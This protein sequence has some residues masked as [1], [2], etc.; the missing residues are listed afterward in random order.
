M[1][2]AKRKMS[3]SELESDSDGAKVEAMLDKLTLGMLQ[4]Q[5]VV[6]DLSAKSLKDSSLENSGCSS[7]CGHSMESRSYIVNWREL[8]GGNLYFNPNCKLH[9][10]AFLNKLKK[11][12]DEAGVPESSHVGL[13]VGC[14]RGSAADWGVVRESSFTTF[15]EFEVSFLNRYWDTERQRDLYMELNYGRF[16]TGNMAEYFLN[17]VGRVFIGDNTR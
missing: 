11:L 2:K 15:K 3:L 8:G 16:E 13:A 5:Q 7:G 14:L 10:K 1:P 17:L 4:L 9:P 6:S 12:F